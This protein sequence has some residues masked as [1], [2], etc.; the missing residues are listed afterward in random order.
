MAAEC[1][2]SGRLSRYKV[3]ERIKRVSRRVNRQTIT[4]MPIDDVMA[5]M[6]SA[7]LLVA[8]STSV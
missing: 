5:W 6:K 2:L 7:S 8:V 3:K 1:I 4:S